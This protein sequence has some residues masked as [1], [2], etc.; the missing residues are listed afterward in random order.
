[1][2]EVSLELVV[3]VESLP[4]N[5]GKKNSKDGMA[6]RYLLPANTNKYIIV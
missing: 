5:E 1:M 4:D 3:Y 2:A 6:H